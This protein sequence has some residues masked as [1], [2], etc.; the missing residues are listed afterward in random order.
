MLSPVNAGWLLFQ[1]PFHINVSVA[2]ALSAAAALKST[3]PR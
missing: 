3:W 2:T 1:T